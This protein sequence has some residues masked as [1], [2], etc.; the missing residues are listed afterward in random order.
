[1]TL[2]LDLLGILL[3]PVVAGWNLLDEWADI[4]DEADQP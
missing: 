1:M 2:L 3:R 4:D